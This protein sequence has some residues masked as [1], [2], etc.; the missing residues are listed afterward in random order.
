MIT[1]AIIDDELFVRKSLE[2]Y[3]SSVAGDVV[4]VAGAGRSVSELT[5]TLPEAPD[6]VV[7][8]VFLRDGT[9]LRD[10]VARLRGWGSAVVVFSRN[11]T[12]PELR[13]QAK[14]AGALGFLHKDE[15]EELPA[16]IRAAADGELYITPQLMRF[17]LMA[18]LGLT[19]RQEEVAG[20]LGAGLSNREIAGQLGISE[21][22]VKEHVWRIKERYQKARRPV[23]DR[24]DL[25]A[26]LRDDGLYQDPPP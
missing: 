12:S 5:E 1:V 10:N 18:K 22:V 3:T 14:D 24:E 6:V 4:T 15:L 17:L 2:A 11:D 7:L 13:W 25:R 19:R 16:A 26:H 21:D 23:A 20:Y 9:R 8:D